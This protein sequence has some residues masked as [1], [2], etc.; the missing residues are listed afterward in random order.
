MTQAALHQLLHQ[1]GPSHVLGF[2]LVLARIAPLFVLAPLFS[3]K[4]VPPQVRA[5]VALALSLG[6]TAIATHGLRIPSDA[7]SIA[8]LFVC[9]ALIG[10][11]FALAV[12]AVFA[13]VSSAGALL[14][15][16][17]GFSYGSLIDPIDGT[18]GGTLANLYN[19]VGL[20]LFIAIGGDAW[21]LRGIAR[22]FSLVPLTRAPDINTLTG[23]VVAAVGTLFVGA[24]EVAAPAML[25]LLVT[26]VAFGMVSRVVPQLNVFA[27]G[28][29]LKI[30]VAL[31]IVVAALPFLGG[32]I[33]DQIGSG[34]TSI[35]QAI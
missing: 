28:F 13:A 20:M 4:M 2:F 27:V 34:V 31:L 22:T 12:A 5:I 11:G 18:Q 7:L 17:S 33:S 9:N 1:I 23:G 35:V 10:L 25:A 15:V 8:G 29:P 6:L 32:F 21:L 26:D 14:D 16:I 24:L 30:G 3:S 19:L